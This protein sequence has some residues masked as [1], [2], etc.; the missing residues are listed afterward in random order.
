MINHIEAINTFI[1]KIKKTQTQNLIIS[2]LPNKLL[3]SFQEVL[4]M[5]NKQ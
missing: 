3:L 5:E 4:K 1:I 2:N